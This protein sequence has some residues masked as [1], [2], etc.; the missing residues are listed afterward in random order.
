MN[1]LRVLLLASAMLSGASL[2][3]AP[4]N[5]NLNDAHLDYV[6]LQGG[7]IR[8]VLPPDGRDAKAYVA[9]FRMRAVP[10]SNAEF[11][12]FVRANPSWQRDRIVRLLALPSYLRHWGGALQLASNTLGPNKLN[13]GS[14]RPDQPVT[15]VSWFAADAYCKAE[16]GRLPTWHEWE[17]AAADATRRDAREDPLWR[18]RILRWYSRPSTDP[19]PRVGQSPRNIY[20][21]RDLHG[22]VWEWVDDFNGIMLSGDN[23]E[24]GD[25]DLL[26]F[27]GAGAASVQDR[28]NYAVLMRLAML[29]SLQARY[30]TANL[31]FR[32]VREIKG[33]KR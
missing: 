18:D 2:Y 27:C 1:A 5:V 11:L 22:V 7:L 31:G 25:P 19:L 20:G 6:N 3:A 24:Q 29:S 21:V 33:A 28:D 16:G 9:P 4:A 30:T 14:N 23:R 13:P 8:S 12:A 15:Q 10:V 32:C 17:F 26:K